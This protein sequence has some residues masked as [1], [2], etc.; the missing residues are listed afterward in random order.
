M[1]EIAEVLVVAP[2]PDGVGAGLHHL[3]DAGTSLQQQG[4]RVEGV[5]ANR[6]EIGALVEAYAVVARSHPQGALARRAHERSRELVAFEDEAARPGAGLEAA[7]VAQPVHG[8]RAHRLAVDERKRVRHGRGTVLEVVDP[9]EGRPPGRQHRGRMH[10]LELRVEEIVA[11]VEPEHP[12]VHRV[13]RAGRGIVERVARRQLGRRIEDQVQL[14]RQVGLVHAIVQLADR[15]GRAV[16]EVAPVGQRVQVQIGAH[17]GGHGNVF[18]R[19]V[20][21]AGLRRGHGRARRPGAP[22]AQALVVE[23]E[24]RPL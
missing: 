1:L 24:E 3:G 9:T 19:Q 17:F 14:S 22:L 13:R 5:R 12:Q 8:D 15:S 2:A 7:H 10:S 4:Q 16:A 11:R 18:A 6:A 21:E 20:A 23:Q